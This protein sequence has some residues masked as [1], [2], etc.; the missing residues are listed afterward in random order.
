ML[1]LFYL[2]AEDEEA[3]VIAQANV[4]LSDS[5]DFETDRIIAR[6]DGDYPVVE[7]QQVDLIDIAPNQISGISASL[8]P[9]LEHDDANRALMG[10]NMMR[11]AVPLLRPNKSPIVGTGL[12][13]QV[14]TDSRILIN[15]EGSGTVEY[16]DADKITIK[17]KRNEDEDLVN[18]DSATK[19]YKLT[20]FQKKKQKPKNIK[21]KKRTE[22][23]LKLEEVENRYKEK[24]DDLRNTLLEKLNILVSVKG[25]G[26]LKIASSVEDY[27]NVSGSDWT[28]DADKNELIKQLIHNYKI[29]YNDLQGIKNREKFAISIG[30]ELP[31]G[32]MKLAKV[33]IA[34][35]RKLNVGDKMAGRHG[36]KGIVSRIVREEDM[37]FL[38][39][40]TAVD[41][42]L[43]PLGVPSRMNIGQIYETVLGWAGKKL[44][45]ASLLPTN[46]DVRS[47]PKLT[48]VHQKAGT[49]ATTEILICMMWQRRTDLHNL[50]TVG[51]SLHNIYDPETDELL[52]EADQLIDEKLAKKIEAAGIESVEARSPLTCETKRVSVRSVNGRNLATR[53]S[54]GIVEMDEV[55]TIKSEGEDGNTTDIVVSRSTEFRLVMDNEIRTVIMTAN[56][57]YGA[58]LA[59][60][61]GDKVKKGDLICKW[62]PY[63]A[64]IIAETSGKVEYED[65]IQGVSFQLEIDEQTGFEEKV[66][67]DSRN[68][69]AVPTLRVVDAKGVEQIIIQPSGWKMTSYVQVLHFLDGSVTPDDILSIK[70][71]TAVQ[72]YLVNEIQEVYRLQ[73][74][75]IDDKHFEIIVRQMMTKVEIVDGGDTQFLEGS[76]EHKNDFIEENKRV[77]GLKVV[78][79]PGDSKEFKA[80]Q[81]I[82][83]REP[84]R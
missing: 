60:K 2:N 13:K 34:K 4:E 8:I 31:A 22:R 24:F 30:D 83:A 71:P 61:P 72:E 54:G 5:G 58:E 51:S 52:V 36:N 20:K 37:P 80:G 25:K 63:N 1:I 62:D 11:Q 14:A 27:V 68:K 67:S 69:K 81:M 45:F 66:I 53:Q 44:G 49:S 38:E 48:E 10:S 26:L 47:G 76:L 16:V 79:N 19:S 18:F 75:K 82:T 6:L 32:I 41:I 7:P 65:I 17:Y 3:K 43:N 59:V 15:A 77:F 35:K 12:E 21:T 74:V 73:G 9:F 84:E 55:K 70:G 28:V 40:G 23:E 64:V 78:I 39:D 29:K 57:P 42:V 50:Q 56:V 33:Y 46:L